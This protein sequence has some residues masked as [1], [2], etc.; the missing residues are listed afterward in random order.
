LEHKQE[1][2]IR[3]VAVGHNKW[4]KRR[5]ILYKDKD[6]FMRINLPDAYIDDLDTWLETKSWFTM[7]AAGDGLALKIAAAVAEGA[8]YHLIAW[9]NR[10]ANSM[11]TPMVFEAL[12]LP[13]E[14]AFQLSTILL[15]VIHMFRLFNL[16]GPG[17]RKSVHALLA[18]R[19]RRSVPL[20]SEEHRELRSGP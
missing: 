13:G 7:K 9:D 3:K 8:A 18:C 1:Y 12:F 10:R 17:P 11:D 6:G 20:S 2:D 16:K 4:L 19:I 14:H 15:H 5:P